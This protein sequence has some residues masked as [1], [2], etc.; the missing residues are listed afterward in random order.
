MPLIYVNPAFERMTG[1][2]LDEILYQGL[3]QFSAARFGGAVGDHV[4][5]S[6]RIVCRTADIAIFCAVCP[7]LAEAQVQDQAVAPNP[8]NACSR[9]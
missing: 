5:M 2:T 3:R 1:Y 4:K 7:L 6:A 8:I 9:W